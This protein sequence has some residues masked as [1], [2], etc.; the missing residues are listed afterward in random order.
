MK[1]I[2]KFS[3]HKYEFLRKH[4]FCILEIIS[5]IQGD[6]SF[7]NIKQTVLIPLL[8]YLTISKYQKGT[9]KIYDGVEKEQIRFEQM[10]EFIEEEMS[11][12]D[13]QDTY[14]KLNQLFIILKQK[15]IDIYDHDRSKMVY[16]WNTVSMY[17]GYN[18]LNMKQSK[19]VTYGKYYK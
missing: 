6:I 19:E 16:S 17:E 2:G 12:Q 11:L 7:N 13:S 3:V 9:R 8:D 5:S 1:S 15:I 14:I 4:S 10:I 18:H